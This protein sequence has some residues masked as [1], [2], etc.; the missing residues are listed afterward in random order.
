MVALADPLTGLVHMLAH[1][2]LA[3]AFAAGGLIALASGLVGFFLVVRSQVFSGDAL[4]HVAFT[5]ALAALALGIDLRVGL[6]AACIVFAVTLSALGRRGRADDVAIGNAFAW[7]LGLGVFFLTVYTSSSS[8]SNG[9][10]GVTV[11]FGSIFGL[12]AGQAQVAEVVAAVVIAGLVTVARPLLFASVD[13]DVA[14][15][16]GVPVR[17]LGVG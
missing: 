6:Y 17:L 9:R 12:G 16:R 14:A 15:A 11:L 7:V 8:G 5:G 13:A 3:R 2:Y 1:P 4:S 10:A